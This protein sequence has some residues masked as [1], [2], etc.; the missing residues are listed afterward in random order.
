MQN[1]SAQVFF[2]KYSPT[3]DWEQKQKNEKEGNGDERG[4][5]MELTVMGMKVGAGT[6]GSHSQGG[7]TWVLLESLGM[8]NWCISF[9]GVKIYTF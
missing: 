7:G 9:A 4:S 2:S 3:Y 8:D 6:Q 1:K 5:N